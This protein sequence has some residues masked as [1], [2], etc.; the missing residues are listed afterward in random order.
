MYNN[1]L[2]MSADTHAVTM[3]GVRNL[4]ELWVRD[5]LNIGVDPSLL[6]E[7]MKQRFLQAGGTIFE[8]TQFKG[9]EVHPDGISI[10]FGPAPG[11]PDV[12][13]ANRPTAL[14]G[15]AAAKAAPSVL[16]SRMIIDCM[17]HYSPIVKQIRGKAKPDGMCLVVGSCAEGESPQWIHAACWAWQ[18]DVHPSSY[19]WQRISAKC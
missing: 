5:T 4:Q 18:V 2:Y 7:P 9:A 6:L 19:R 17:G 13:D 10:R 8:H 11:A 3:L 1:T 14:G 15:G 16:R 12:G